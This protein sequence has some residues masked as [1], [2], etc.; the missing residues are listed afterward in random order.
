MPALM[1]LL[2]AALCILLNPAPPKP[3]R[4]VD[5][6]EVRPLMPLE[7]VVL[8]DSVPNYYEFCVELPLKE[9]SCTTVRAIRALVGGLRRVDGSADQGAGVPVRV[10]V[11]HGRPGA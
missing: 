4:S 1:V 5:Y 7:R 10:D 3:L 2:L 9:R 11:G 6:I 8:P